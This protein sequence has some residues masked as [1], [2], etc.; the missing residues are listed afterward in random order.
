MDK[1]TKTY[2]AY[3]GAVVVASIVFAYFYSARKYKKRLEI[4]KAIDEAEEMPTSEP[5]KV[6]PFTSMLNNP[7]PTS[8]GYSFDLNKYF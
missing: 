4:S 2:L 3:G 7:P 5:E 8:V 6:N 1:Q